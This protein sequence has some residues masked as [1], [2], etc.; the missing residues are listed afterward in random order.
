MVRSVE[1]SQ[2]LANF[3]S[4]ELLRLPF[5]PGADEKVP[6]LLPRIPLSVA[7]FVRAELN[8]G[9]CPYVSASAERD[10]SE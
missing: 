7:G 10:A 6:L 9:Q 5:W 3:L 2:G 8:V 1:N 4:E